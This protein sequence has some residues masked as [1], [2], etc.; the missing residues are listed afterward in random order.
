MGN[1]GNMLYYTTRCETSNDREKGV[2]QDLRGKWREDEFFQQVLST[3]E[4]IDTRA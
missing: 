4:I 2:P 3:V 1:W